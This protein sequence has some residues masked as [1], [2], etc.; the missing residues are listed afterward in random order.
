VFVNSR[1]Y[2]KED[3]KLN[4]R[5]VGKNFEA[6]Q[7]RQIAKQI[8]LKPSLLVKFKFIEQ[9]ASGGNA[10]AEQYLEKL[11]NEQVSIDWA[12]RVL[13]NS[14]RQQRMLKQ[15]IDISATKTKMTWWILLLLK[16][17]KKD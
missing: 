3:K 6:F 2:W 9:Q 12:H 17:K 7:L 5:Y 16:C 8:K 14:I 11:R 4:K 10:V 1:I 15:I 13:I